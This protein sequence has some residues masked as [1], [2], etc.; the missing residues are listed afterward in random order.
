MNKEQP[1][2]YVIA[3]PNGAGKTTFALRYLPE[4]TGCRNFINADL[5]ADGLSPLDPSKV[6]VEAGK[7]LLREIRSNV[8]KG[9]GFA[10][11]TT[12]SGRAYIRLL[13]ELRSKGWKV[14]LFYLWIPS[15]S[16]SSARVQQR[17]EAGGHDIPAEAIARRYKRTISNFLNIFTPLCDEVV[18]Y[19]NSSPKPVLTFEQRGDARIIIDKQRYDM[20]LRCING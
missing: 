4:I 8:E 3:G 14:V 18:C 10:F 19:D 6:Q 17:V 2:C 12:L 15:A 20:I 9:E 7:I 13:K 1:T 16:F 5:I 11:E